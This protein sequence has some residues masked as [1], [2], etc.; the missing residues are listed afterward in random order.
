MSSSVSC[1]LVVF[2]R[3]PQALRRLPQAPHTLWF[4]KIDVLHSCLSDVCCGRHGRNTVLLT[5]KAK[6]I[7]QLVHPPSQDLPT[8]IMVSMLLKDYRSWRMKKLSGSPNWNAYGA[9]R[10]IMQPEGEQR[11]V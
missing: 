11:F 9:V 3:L 8:K 7:F 4:R 6:L 1:V 5:P 10:T 2:S